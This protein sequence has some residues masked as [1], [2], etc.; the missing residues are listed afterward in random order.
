[1]K[2]VYLNLIYLMVLVSTINTLRAQNPNGNQFLHEFPE[3]DAAVSCIPDINGDFAKFMNPTSYIPYNDHRLII[4]THGKIINVSFH[5]FQKDGGIG[6]FQNTP[7]HIEYLHMALQNTNTYFRTGESSHSFLDEDDELPNFHSQIQFTLGE[8]GSERIFFH[9]NTSLACGINIAS[10]TLQDFMAQVEPD[11]RNRLI[12]TFSLRQYGEVRSDNIEITN[13]GSGYQTVPDV[14]FDPP[15]AEGYAIIENGR[16]SKIEIEQTGNYQGCDPPIITFVGGNPAIP[17]EAYVK[18]LDGGPGGTAPVPV[19]R[20]IYTDLQYSWAA[21]VNMDANLDPY[22]PVSHARTIAHEIGHAL[23][24]HHTYDE[25]ECDTEDIDYLDDVFQEEEHCPHLVDWSANLDPSVPRITNN[26]MGGHKD[27]QYI[28]PKQAGIMHRTLALTYARR[29]V[30]E[31]TY[32]STPYTVSGQEKWDFDIKLYHDIIIPQGAELEITCRVIMPWRGRIIVKE[33]GVLKINGGIVT[34]DAKNKLWRGIEVHGN[35]LASQSPQTNQG[36]VLL[37]N[38]LIENA[39]IGILLD[40]RKQQRDGGYEVSTSQGGGIVIAENS[41]FRNNRVSVQFS[42]YNQDN[43]STFTNCIFNYNKILNDSEQQDYHMKF[44]GVKDIN[45]VSCKF[46]SNLP[47][48]DHAGNGVYSYNSGINILNINAN[49]L[50]VF[51]NLSNGVLATSN[52]SLNTVDIRDAQ[53]NRCMNGIVLSGLTNAKVISNKFQIPSGIISPGPIGLH[54]QTCSHYQVEDNFFG[55]QGVQN[56]EKGWLGI[57][58][59]NSGPM[60]NL[61]YNN[62]FTYLSYG[63]LAHGN[64]RG[65]GQGLQ[66]RCNDFT[67]VDYDVIVTP[68]NPPAVGDGIAPLQGNS[69]SLPTDPAGNTFTKD[70]YPDREINYY[71]LV[72]EYGY[73]ITYYHHNPVTAPGKVEP[74]PVENVTTFTEGVHYVN[75]GTSCPGTINNDYTELYTMMLAT[76][77]SAN[78]YNS[79][80]QA[81]LD[82]GD[83]DQLTTTVVTSFPGDGLVIRQQLLDES[84]YLSDTVMAT[85]ITKEE[86]L[87]NAMIRDVLVANPHAAK[88]EE[89]LNAL[90]NR[91]TPMPS[92]M[93]DE[94]LEGAD[95]TG[96]KEILEKTVLSFE[97]KRGAAQSGLVRLLLDN[98]ENGFV[99]SLHSL[100]YTEQYPAAHY[101]LATAH[102]SISDTLSAL[103]L[104]N[105]I[106]NSF[107]LD[108]RQQDIHNAMMALSGINAALNTDTT[109]L[110]PDSAQ[111]ITLFDIF[112]QKLGLAGIYAQNLLIAAGLLEYEADIEIPEMLKFMPVFQKERRRAPEGPAYIK[113][114]PNP[115]R[116]YITAEYKLDAEPSNAQLLVIAADGRMIRQVHLK[117]SQDQVVIELQNLPAGIYFIQLKNNHKMLGTAKFNIL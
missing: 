78:I 10:N 37:N 100:I 102:M 49:N 68:S 39:L 101:L 93:L 67:D 114:F 69:G 60:S 31:D 80:L 92:Y 46:N 48:V 91:F 33:G 90:D 1:M 77:D 81:L 21:L 47:G 88:S 103:N 71:N 29:I 95:I 6:N 27:S 3:S 79:Q 112:D 74:F 20:F 111:V 99:D 11:Y 54:L 24:L 17:A 59:E 32:T 87:N 50:T 58:V 113:V 63:I 4:P 107:T 42:P 89:L 2:E 96:P 56:P 70:D 52:Y 57:A 35:P 109:F 65:Q 9:E 73:T 64:N 43:I 108:A 28:S 66:I 117:N 34:T 23:G 41:E 40:E 110:Q 115:A 98:R 83:T 44:Y 106:P 51:N 84:P 61:I 7:Q 36:V 8:K 19:P 45:L 18:Y 86:V 105:N 104:L 5:I 62:T 82:G 30:N 13:S 14:I 85:A 55:L 53:F 22:N 26:L 72:S 25:T 38:A 15:G 76:E 97:N 16:V 116:S 75:K 94:I 12:I